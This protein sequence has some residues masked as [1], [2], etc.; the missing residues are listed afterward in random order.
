M[1]WNGVMPISADRLRSKPVIILV[2]F[3]LLLFLCLMP[4]KNM[5]VKL[6][7][8]L[9]TICNLLVPYYESMFFN[10]FQAL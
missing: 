1:A 6:W 2:I 5:N 8:W 9:Q 10:D 4:L 7:L 3:A